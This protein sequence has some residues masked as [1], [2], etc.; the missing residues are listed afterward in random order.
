VSELDNPGGRGAP[1]DPSPAAPA[2]EAGAGDRGGRQEEEGKK[3]R[4]RGGK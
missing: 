3:V 2:V 1:P 4:E